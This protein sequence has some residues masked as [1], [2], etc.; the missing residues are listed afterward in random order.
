[1]NDTPVQI[2]RWTRVGLGHIRIQ[3]PIALDEESEPEP[4]LAV[5]AGGP[6]DYLA[7]H[8]S[9]PA[10]VVEIADSSLASDRSTRVAS[11]PAP[12]CPTPGSSISW[13]VSSRST[14]SQ[15]PMLPRSTGGPTPWGTR[16]GP[17]SM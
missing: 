16:C 17:T 13:P 6:R 14:A 12:A 2:R 9:R 3:L 1:M 10:L 8:P 5:V 11:L 15:Y 7:D 4:D